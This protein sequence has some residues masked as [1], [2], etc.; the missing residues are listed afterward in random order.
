MKGIH[1]TLGQAGMS[2]DE[3]ET[4][5][6]GIVPKT[7]R[8]VAKVW[9]S[10][11]VSQM[12]EAVET[13]GRPT[14]YKVGNAPLRRFFAASSTGRSKPRAVRGLPCNFYSNLWWKGLTEAQR[15]AVKRSEQSKSIP[16]KVGNF[17]RVVM[18]AHSEPCRGCLNS[19]PYHSRSV[20]TL[21]TVG[22]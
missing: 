4:E 1:E 22:M 10:E 16:A 18:L 9:L 17:W 14:P 19:T 6:R 11:E 3:T 12:W 8:R 20:I 15:H 5:G 21:K 13:I 7:L 2:S